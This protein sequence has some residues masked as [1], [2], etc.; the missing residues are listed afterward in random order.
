LKLRT[1]P[2]LETPARLLARLKLG[3]EEYCQ[4]LLTTLIL[5]RP[6]P[7]WNSRLK[8]SPA[9]FSFLR[10]V[11][12]RSFGGR[13]PGNSA[14]FVD[15]F[16]LPPRNDAERGGAPDY[17]VLWD[18]RLWLIE[19]KTEKASHR[20]AQIPG[21]FELAHHHY[22]DTPIDLL[23]VTPP[24]DAPYVPEGSWGRYAHTTW[25]DLVE[26]VRSS[27]PSGAT[28]GRQ[29]VIDGLMEGIDSLAV[30]HAAWRAARTLQ[31]DVQQDRVAVASGVA[32]VPAAPSP[33]EAALAA[34]SLTGGDGR[35]RAVEVT[36]TDLDDLM[37]FR[38]SVRDA[39]AAS[40]NNS[41]LRHIMPWIWRKESTGAPLTIGGREHGMEV[42]LSRY[43]SPRY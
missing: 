6:Y 13:W 40:P 29:D 20:A 28:P 5:D 38:L 2:E 10:A 37:S 42:R 34:A 41:P 23:Y 39:L 8:P 1:R 43:K 21:Y 33:L 16:E 9:G 32:Q 22:P 11:Y 30:E 35:Q 19:L 3:R 4:R 25:A 14:V 18:D 24:M 12:E 27:W 17:A 15:E 26:P 7:R 31:N 36:A